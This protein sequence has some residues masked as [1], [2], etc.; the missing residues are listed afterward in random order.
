M[1]NSH[2]F[3][4]L[5]FTIL[6][7]IDLLLLWGLNRQMWRVRAVRR[8]FLWAPL[9]GG[10]VIGLWAIGT[11]A[12]M[13][14]LVSFASTLT[15]GLLTSLVALLAAL[16]LSGL[17]LSGERI[18]DWF[19]ARRSDEIVETEPIAV[20][21]M[22]TASGSIAME[23]VAI[24]ATQM[25]SSTSEEIRTTSAP[26]RAGRPAPRHVV[27]RV[28]KGR[29][30]FMTRAAA[31]IPGATLA[32]SGYG[33][34]SSHGSV[35]M[36]EIPM[37][38][39][40]LHPDLE[41]LRILHLTD[42]HL[43][44]YVGLDDL[45]ELMQQAK[46]V[47]PDL[48]LVSGDIADDLAQLPGA[49]R[50]FDALRPRYGTYATL[51]NH[52]YFR[53]IENVI[54]I[55]DAGP[56]PL[57]RGTGASLKIGGAELYVGGA[58]DPVA[59]RQHERNHRFLQQSVAS[60]FDGASSD[61]FHLL[62]SHRPEGFDVAV[63]EGIEMTISGHT[64]GAQLGFNGRSIFEPWMRERYLWGP[65]ERDGLRLYTSAGVGHWFP[66]RLGCPPEA[67]VYVLRNDER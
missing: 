58:D 62:M 52:E 17:M 19:A 23:P 4:L 66:F 33:I 45:E 47:R 48:M 15:A 43:G 21:M 50:M 8:A 7:L 60:A 56:I 13:G 26:S 31:A 11:A 53:G 34:L 32:T 40:G 59:M 12:E 42:I 39:P 51:G 14:G 16:P 2:L 1:F 29:R 35:R 10:V 5:A 28:N 3:S 18:W 30:R 20:A 25:R 6:W 41:G 22:A 55:F 44:Y 46:G 9:L 61:A 54:K 38:F 64:H 49:L 65:Y 27:E 63:E 36:P 37:I 57:L 24:E 67:P